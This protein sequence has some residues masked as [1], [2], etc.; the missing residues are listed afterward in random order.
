MSANPPN[1]PVN[2]EEQDAGGNELAPVALIATHDKVGQPIR[3]TEQP[4]LVVV[5]ET[6][7]GLLHVGLD[8]KGRG[9]GRVER[10]KLKGGLELL[11]RLLFALGKL[12]GFLVLGIS[13]ISP[14]F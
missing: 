11:E 13:R 9:R 4:L 7:L 3:A 1:P 6:L 10:I 5:V 14:F 2:V 12:L 8:C